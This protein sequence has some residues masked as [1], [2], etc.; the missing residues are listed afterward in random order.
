MKKAGGSLRSPPVNR[1]SLRSAR[2]LVAD[3][4]LYYFILFPI[5]LYSA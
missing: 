2:M 5:N 4:L 3:R 1:A